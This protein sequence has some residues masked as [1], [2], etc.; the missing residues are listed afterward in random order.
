MDSERTSI[1]NDRVLTF[2]TFL[3]LFTFQL[4]L[5]RELGT[6]RTIADKVDWLRFP[7]A[8][9]RRFADSTGVSQRVRCQLTKIRV[10]YVRAID[11][12]GRRGSAE[13]GIGYPW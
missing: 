3:F 5:I 8:T 6:M 2:S 11:D 10:S 12:R 7:S 9:T 13:R 4:D 1:Y